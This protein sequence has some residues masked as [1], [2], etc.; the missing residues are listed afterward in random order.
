MMKGIS[1]L[2]VSRGRVRLLKE[3]LDSII[4]A[5]ANC[6]FSSEVIIVDNSER[7]DALI[8]ESL[9]DKYDATYYYDNASVAIKRNK[10]ASLAKY[11]ILFFCDSDC[12][13]T[14]DILNQH[15]SSYETENVGAVAGPVILQGEGNSFNTMIMDTAWCTA[16]IQP[17][18]EPFLEWGATANFSVKQSVFNKIGGFNKKFPNKPGGEDVDIGFRI[19]NEG[20]LIKSSPQ[21]VVYHSNKTWLKISDVSSRLFSYGK[22][23][24]LLVK[25]HSN[26]LIG[27]VNWVAL[28]S[29]YLLFSIIAAFV[30]DWEIIWTA[31]IFATI[32]LLMICLIKAIRVKKNI[33]IIF[34]IELLATIEKI[35]T[36]AGCF[37][38][39]TIK[40]LFRQVLYSQYQEH[41]T[42]SENQWTYFSVLTAM[43]IS[44][45][46]LFFIILGQ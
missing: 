26:R 24:V 18:K 31:P 28:F 21:A 43:S 29:V 3:L 22:S 25:E 2:I 36:I 41:G 1:I 38:Y 33:V 37:K 19:R 20:Y 9:C 45:L 5:R 39:K 16:F 30:V 40:P 35:G 10:A 23:N 17:L 6:S 44:F 4:I 13:V 7:D 42:I 11:E 8:I 27:D 32:Y 15:I 12:I 46:Y 14:S 34:K